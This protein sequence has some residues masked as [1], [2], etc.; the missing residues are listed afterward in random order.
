MKYVMCTYTVNPLYNTKL[1]QVMTNL[2]NRQE[3]CVRLTLVLHS[4]GTYQI[5]LVLNC[6]MLLWPTPELSTKETVLPLQY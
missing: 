1:L 3:S 2:H 5:I 6:G 4:T